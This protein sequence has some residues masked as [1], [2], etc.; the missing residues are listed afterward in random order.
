MLNATGL[1]KTYILPRKRVEVLKGASVHVARGERVAVVGRSG[2]GKST[3]LHVLGG[4]D[5]PEAGEVWIDGQPLYAVSQRARTALRAAKIGFVF[6]SYH[7]LS[8]MDVTENVMLP[9]MTGAV[10]LTRAQMR[11]RALDLLEQVG[12]ADRATHMPL[13]LSGGEQQRVALARA[14]VTDPA[15]ILADE[16]TG[17]LDRLTGAQIMELLFGLSCTRELALVMVTHSPETA[18]LCD[19]ILELRDGQLSCG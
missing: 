2:S 19:R 9:A 8:E 5:R 13:V 14:L 1:C 17:N 18:A 11:R 7:L 3:L 12:L 10:R 6:Q 15:L 16:P 4:L